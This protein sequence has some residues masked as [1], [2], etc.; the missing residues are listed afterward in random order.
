MNAT[1]RLAVSSTAAALFLL[2]LGVLV[3]T[4]FQAADRLASLEAEPTAILTS[5][6]SEEDL[7]ARAVRVEFDL[8]VSDRVV[9]PTWT[10]LITAVHTESDAVI[11]SGDVV[12]A[13]DGINRIAIATPSPLHRD[14]ISGMTGA[15][16]TAVQE[17]LV[18]RGLLDEVTGV[19]DRATTAAVKE[20]RITLGE[21]KPPGT[22][23]RSLFVWLPHEQWSVGKVTASVGTPAPA[24]GQVLFESLPTV[25][26]ARLVELNDDA[27]TSAD[28]TWKITL[29]DL[30][31][32][33]DESGEI[34]SNEL[35]VL[36]VPARALIAKQG[37]ADSNGVAPTLVAQISRV[38]AQAFLTI[39]ATALVTD[40]AGACVWVVASPFLPE[41][42]QSIDVDIVGSG[43]RPGT[44]NIAEIDLPDQI[45]A[46]PTEMLP[47]PSCRSQQ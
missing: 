29:D 39:P 13:I 16:V 28:A 14:L 35:G 45:L 44:A 10:G 34:P 23:D 12:I 32:F 21:I 5:A 17:F 11:S 27:V 41:T 4:Q 36:D 31:I 43:S 15:D 37:V 26:A 18:S 22:L 7:E 38:E 33:L 30:V 40:D 9:A 3:G 8:A 24:A 19:Y 42:A 1:T 46:N 20:L 2:P 6:Q 47:D 25:T